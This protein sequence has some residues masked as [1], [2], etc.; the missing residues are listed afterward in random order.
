LT[1]AESQSNRETA[2]TAEV[3]GT[4]T[5][6]L[7]VRRYLPA[8]LGFCLAKTKNI[9]DSEDIMQDVFLKAFKKLNTLRD[10]ARARAWLLKIARRVCIDYYR[11]SSQTRKMPNDV[12]ASTDSQSEHIDRLHRAIAKLPDGYRELITL[13][14][15][16]GRKCANVAEC[17]G[18]SEDAVRSRLVRA[19][20]RLH[21]LLLEDPL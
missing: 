11:N 4:L 21:N 12:Q 14:Y 3:E 17:L 13:Y 7:L 18:I 16:D 10:H 6:E 20:L 15:L 1:K 2:N 5:P 19:R 8:V 9:H